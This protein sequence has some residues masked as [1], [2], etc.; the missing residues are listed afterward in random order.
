MDVAFTLNLLLVLY[1][2][3]SPALYFFLLLV[4][5]HWDTHSEFQH[6]RLVANSVAVFRALC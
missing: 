2:T 4:W 1:P 5:G 3:L 6:E